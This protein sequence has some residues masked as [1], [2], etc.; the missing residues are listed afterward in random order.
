MNF[1]DAYKL[2]GILFMGLVNFTFGKLNIVNAEL[3]CCEYRKWFPLY[4]KWEGGWNSSVGLTRYSSIQPKISP[5]LENPH[6]W[7]RLPAKLI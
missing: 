3:C 1:V 7:Q 6:A 4:F 5:Q 2:L